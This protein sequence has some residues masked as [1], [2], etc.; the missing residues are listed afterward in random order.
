MSDT[1]SDD[2]AK[3]IVISLAGRLPQHVGCQAIPEGD[4]FAK[5]FTQVFGPD[6][7]DA[8]DAWIGANCIDLPDEEDA[9]AAAVSG[10]QFEGSGDTLDKAFEAAH[11][12]M[13]MQSAD[14][15]KSEV[16]SWGATKG[17][18]TNRL[19]YWVRV[20]QLT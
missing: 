6:T 13:K 15:T 4:M 3:Y 17:G 8:C 1:R 19:N 11:A 10:G 18:F 2:S 9:A 5:I 16:A 20:T 7:K 12:Q 14:F